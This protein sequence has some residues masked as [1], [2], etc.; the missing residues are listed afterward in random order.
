MAEIIELATLITKYK[1]RSRLSYDNIAKLSGVPKRTIMSWASGLSKKPRRWQDLAKFAGALRLSY[2]ELNQLLEVAGHKSLE[3]LLREGIDAHLLTEWADEG[4]KAV[5]QAPRGV[6]LYRG[7]V[8]PLQRVAEQVVSDER[9]CVIEG[10]GG[11]GKSSLALESARRLAP[12]YRD[13]VLYADLRQ[14]TLDEVVDSWGDAIGVQYGETTS[15]DAKVT[16]LWGYLSRK[17]YLLLIDDAVSLKVTQN[18]AS[19]LSDRLQCD[20]YDA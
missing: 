11:I 18:A 10:M 4:K 15:A 3:V 17:S 2:E 16:Y 1:N 12:N 8:E 13:G 14:M 6:K 19:F 9:V 5:Y 7:R 20:C